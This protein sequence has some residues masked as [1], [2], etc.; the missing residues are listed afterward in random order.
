MIIKELC[1]S[2][3]IKHDLC[4]IYGHM[5]MIVTGGYGFVGTPL[6]Q[7]LVQEGHR[8]TAIGTHFPS[9][10]HKGITFIQSSLRPGEIPPVFADCDA[11]IHLAGANIFHRWT[12]HYKQLILDS[13]IKTARA[14]YEFIAKQPKKPRVFI[15]ASA[16]GY[17]GDRAEELLDETSSAGTGFLASTC[18]E[19]EKAREKF[20][21]LGIRS[22]SI[23]TGVVLGENGGALA[24]MLPLFRLGLGGKLGN[25]RQW[26][27]WI[28]RDDLINIY[29]LALHDTSLSGPINA[30]APQLIRNVEFTKALGRTLKRVTFLAVPSFILRAIFGEMATLFLS[31]QKVKP[32]VLEQLNFVFK[33]PNIQTALKKT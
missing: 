31:S 12:P 23:R 29:S 15:S 22:V 13:R 7:L 2:C 5:H 27:P 19:W 26:F 6:C 1:I 32:T 16:V 3:L 11:I 10:E 28:H 24:Q 8:V 4:A 9:Q 25:G 14:I 21:S 20:S 17:Y 30:V 18:I 33:Y